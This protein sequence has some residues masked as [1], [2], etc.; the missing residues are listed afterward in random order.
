MSNTIA[1]VEAGEACI[2]SKPQDLPVD[3]DKPLPKLGGLF[4]G[5]CNVALC[6]GSVFRMKKDPDETQLKNLIVPD[7]G[8][9]LDLN[10]LKK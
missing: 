4:D 1:V 10:K 2:W 7:D 8:N 5:M 6:D 3:A 9:V